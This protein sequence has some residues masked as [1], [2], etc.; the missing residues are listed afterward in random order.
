MKQPKWSKQEVRL[1]TKH[2][3]KK[4]I[5]EVVKLLPN[6]SRQAV[7]KMASNLLLT[8]FTKNQRDSQR[9]YQYN[10]KFFD[11]PNIKNSYWAG[12]IASDGNLG[13]DGS[14]RITIAARDEIVLRNFKKHVCY[15]GPIKYHYVEGRK[16]ASITIWGAYRWHKMLCENW[17]ISKHQKTQ[18]LQ[19]PI[20]LSKTNA[21]SYVVGLIDGDGWIYKKVDGLLQLGFCGTKSVVEFVRNLFLQYVD[22][23]MTIGLNGHCK[24]NYRF[25]VHKQKDIWQL[26]NIFN[27]VKIPWKLKRKWHQ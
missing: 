17:N 16:Y 7:C 11:R 24:F 1:L 23:K 9:I 27:K 14:I 2:Y 12:F 5:D 13:K 21:M 6:R 19:P 18:H 20:S 25:C 26:I 15:S 10:D 22:S 8:D 3:S 4:K